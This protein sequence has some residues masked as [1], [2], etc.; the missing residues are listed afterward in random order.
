MMFILKSRN[1][2]CILIA[3]KI[4][5]PVQVGTCRGRVQ[6]CVEGKIKISLVTK[7]YVL[8]KRF[9]VFFETQKKKT[10]SVCEK[11]NQSFTTFLV[12]LLAD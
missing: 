7:Y 3:S 6:L 5:Y 11:E 8:C 10:L 1:Q 2:V 4:K 9:P 12:N